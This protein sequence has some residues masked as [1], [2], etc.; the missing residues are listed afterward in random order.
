VADLYLKNT[1][2]KRGALTKFL[3]AGF[4]RIEVLDKN[5]AP[6]Y[7]INPGTDAYVELVIANSSDSTVQA[8]FT[9]INQM[10]LP[11]ILCAS[12]YGGFESISNGEFTFL[13]R[14]PIEYLPPGLYR[15]EGAVWSANKLYD[16]DENLALFQVLSDRLAPMHG[17]S[18]SASF[19][20]R[21][22]WTLLNSTDCTL[23]AD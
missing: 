11:V 4:R 13:V 19:V 22:S 15:I 23:I 17:R 20:S 7:A 8:G 18:S 6:L 12:E 21:E 5:R 16:Q 14:L 10:D 9:V 2:A 1:A 3:E